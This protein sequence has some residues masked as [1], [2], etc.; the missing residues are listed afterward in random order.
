M[1]KVDSRKELP[2]RMVFL[3]KSIPTNRKMS[4]SL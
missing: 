4:T 2:E 3:Y 1:K